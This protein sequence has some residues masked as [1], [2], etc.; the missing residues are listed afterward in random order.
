[1]KKR[2][3]PLKNK[4]IVIFYMLYFGDM[5]SITPFLEVLRRAA[6]GS[7]IILVMDSRFR[8][9]VAGNPDI[10]EFIEVDRKKDKGL[11]AVWKLGKEIGEKYRPDILL[12]L[13]G[14]SRTTLM[15]K[16]MKPK[17]WIGEAGTRF[18]RFFMDIPMVIETYRSHA[19]DKYLDVLKRLG[20]SDLSHS[21]MRTYTLPEWE[22][23][24]AQFFA[25]EGIAPAEK[26]AGF[27]VGSST[28]E[29][30][31]P[32]ESYGKTADHFAEMGLR[33]VFFGVKSELPLIEQALSVMEHRDE[34]VIAAGKLSMGEFIAAAGR[35]SL[36]FTNDSGPM[37][38]FDSR[39]VPTVA[40]FGPSN[41]KF[42]HPLGK[43][44]TAIS[45]W[46]MPMGPEHVNKTIRSGKYTPLSE[47]SVEQVIEAGEKALKDSEKKK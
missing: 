27:S 1:M 33:P 26:L 40:M 25:S 28:K 44:S 31:W 7:K 41:A 11:G 5:V 6:E 9:A 18:D 34:A 37:Y 12:V 21:G 4:T 2:P 30:N 39:G 45:S 32:A 46:D 8:E 29:K 14:T 19:V 36:A 38:V 10:D 35:C 16:A 24:A 43:Y 22:R 17:L 3:I 20:V 15:A 23:K 13:H 42:H 47:I